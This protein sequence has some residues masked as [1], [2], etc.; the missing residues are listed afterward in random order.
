LQRVTREFFL[1]GTSSGP[2]KSA[3]TNHITDLVCVE[4]SKN[5]RQDHVEG[6]SWRH[7]EVCL[8]C[9][10]WCWQRAIKCEDK[11]DWFY[12]YFFRNNDLCQ[13]VRTRKPQQIKSLLNSTLE[14]IRALDLK[15]Q[16]TSHSIW[17]KKND[18]LC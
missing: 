7:G 8:C 4:V 5:Q 3:E 16:Q 11:Q 18:D 17:W 13:M 12:V 14:K 9:K 10:L 2:K 6:S 15:L 1:C